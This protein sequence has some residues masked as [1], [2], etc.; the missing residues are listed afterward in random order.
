MKTEDRLKTAADILDVWAEA[1]R[2]DWGSI[3][4]RS[5]RYQLNKI[6]GYLRGPQGNLDA[7]DVG[8]CT[9]EGPHWIGDGYHTGRCD[10]QA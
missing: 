10:G 6:S 3:D 7:T 1:I 8:V 2:G 9:I 5:C 4:G